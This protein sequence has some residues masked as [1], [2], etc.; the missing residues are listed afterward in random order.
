[1]TTLMK[2]N[3]TWIFRVFP[4]SIGIKKNDIRALSFLL[5]VAIFG[6]LGGCASISHGTAQLKQG[7]L[8][9]EKFHFDDG[10]YA[11]YYYFDLG[12]PLAG[13]PV[14]FFISGSGCSS[15]KLRFPNFFDPIKQKLD[16]YVFVLQK[17]GIG[18]NE[19]GASCSSSFASTDYFDKTVSDQREFINHQLAL[20]PKV[21]RVVLL[22]GASE[23][24]V[25][26][27]KIAS[28]DHRITNL[29]LIG[30][31]G[32]TIRDNLRTL[33]QRVWFLRSP[34]RNFAS[35]ESDPTNTMKNVW[36]HSYKYWSSILDVNIGSL[37]I[38]V[39]IPIVMAMGEQDESVPIEA[40]YALQK[41]FGSLEKDNF[42]LHAFPD[43]DH[44]LYSKARSRSY[45]KE[46]LEAVLDEIGQEKAQ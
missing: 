2:I 10:G 39:D 31:G 44:R 22:M 32:E 18:G 11:N 24:A 42:H 40:A 20:Q 17:R 28:L 45:V 46:F 37:L 29:A 4:M 7:A 36:G 16:A 5:L 41:R 34:E 13:S 21:P 43:A 8:R 9:P 12:N 25:V 1:M 23:G 38:S 6:V 26:A 3:L 14:V 27:A 35:I 33:S 19:D 15:V 30:G